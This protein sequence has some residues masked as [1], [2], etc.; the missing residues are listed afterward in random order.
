[1]TERDPHHH[2]E[3][4]SAEREMHRIEACE[5]C[6]Q[7][8]AGAMVG[9][10]GDWG[11]GAALYAA[12]C[13]DCVQEHDTYWSKRRANRQGRTGRS[14]REAPDTEPYYQHDFYLGEVPLRGRPTGI[15]L[16]MHSQEEP[17]EER[18]EIFP[19]QHPRG[20]RTY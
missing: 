18:H 3:E 14:V 13:P 7:E 10:A 15:H 20:R 6:G 11:S 19:L 16:R 2:P 9:M 12:V 17:Y 5:R 1:M 8:S 4:P